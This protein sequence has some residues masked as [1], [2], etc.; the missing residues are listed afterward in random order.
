MIK[1][2]QILQKYQRSQE[3]EKQQQ[4]EEST[5]QGICR[6]FINVIKEVYQRYYK[7]LY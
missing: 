1:E 3:K 5:N 7:S 2:N 6:K 4:F